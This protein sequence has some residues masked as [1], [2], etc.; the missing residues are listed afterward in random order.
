MRVLILPTVILATAAFSNA[1]AGTDSDD[2]ELIA[3]LVAR[4]SAGD[5]SVTRIDPDIQFVW[6][7]EMPDRRL[8]AGPFSVQWSGQ[9]LARTESTY[10]F[11]L[12]LEG[13][14]AVTLDGREILRG[15]RKMPGWVVSDEIQLAG[16]EHLIAIDFA[17]P[18]P[19]GAIRLFWASE[20]FPLEPIS[21][22]LLFHE[23]GDAGASQVERGE[24]LLTSLRCGACH[25]RNN[26]LPLLNAIPLRQAA[27]GL[28]DDWLVQW[29]Q[30]PVRSRPHARMPAFGFS[31]DEALSIAGYLRAQSATLDEVVPTVTDR[32]AAARRGERLFRSTGC[33]ACHTHGD[34][35]V[36]S[37]FSGGDLTDVGKRRSEVWLWGWLK[38]PAR[39]NRAHRMPVFALSDDER[40][41]LT[42]YLAG[43]S[44]PE[45]ALAPAREDAD[46]TRAGRAL[47]EQSRCNACHRDE[48]DQKP[49]EKISRLD[50]TVT[51]WSRACSEAAPD[52]KVFRPGYSLPEPD[53]LALRAAIASPPN[54]PEGPWQASLRWMKWNNCQKCHERDGGTGLASTAG[55]V[56]QIDPD[57]VG[58]SEALMPPDLTAVGDKLNDSCL[59]TAV[60]G[61]QET[62]RLPWLRVR[63]PQFP[64][65]PM[66]IPGLDRWMIDHDRIPES[67]HG[68]RA[69][70]SPVP[71]E[72]RPAGRVL[73]GTRGFSCVGC[74]KVGKFEP[75]N[76]ALATRGSDLFALDKRMRPEFFRRWVRSPLRVIPNMEMP[77]FDKPNPDL[78]EGN[79]DLQLTA[80][81]AALNDPNG[82]PTLDTSLIEQFLVVDKDGPARIVRDVFHVGEPTRPESVP[83]AFAVGFGNQTNLLFDLDRMALRAWWVGDFARQRS[84]GKSWNWELGAT[85]VSFTSSETPDVALVANED[86]LDKP[87]VARI[88]TGRF[89]KLHRYREEGAGVVIDYRLEFDVGSDRAMLEVQES[90]A[91][92]SSDGAGEA[93]WVRETTIRGIP[94]GYH[95]V[96]R[97]SNEVDRF[98]PLA[99]NE[100]GRAEESRHYSE[101]ATLSAAT[102]SPG[103]VTPKSSIEKLTVVPGYEGTRLPLPWSIMPTSLTWN[104]E[105]VLCFTSL[106]GHVFQARDTD[107]DGIEDTLIVFEEGLASPYGLIADGGDLLV[108]HKPELLRLRDEDGD[109]RSERREVVAD[110]WGFTDDYHDWTTGIVRDTKGNLY[111]GTG[112]DYARKGRSREQGRWR[113]KLLRIDRQ[114][115]TVPLGHALR[116]PTGLAINA[117]D[118]VFV[119]DNQG[120]QNT[121]NEINHLVEGGRYGVPSLFEE[122]F[123]ESPLP[124]AIQVPHPWTR[125]VNGIFFL[126]VNSSEGDDPFAGHG[127]G[128]EYDS[129]F[130]VR[131]TLQRVGATYQGAVY[132]FSRPPEKQSTGQFLGTL[133]G[134]VAPNGDIYIGSFLDSGWLGGPNVGDIVRLRRNGPLTC[135]IR[136]IQA[137]D[138]EFV[139]TFTSPVNREAAGMP[140]NYDISG[141][142][143]VW[144]GAYATP[145]SGRHKLAVRSATVAADGKSVIL[146]TDR[147]K[148]G[149][150]YEVHVGRL[151]GAKGEPLWPDVGHYTM[152]QIP[153][154]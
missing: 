149:H 97:R 7:Q 126:P 83:R 131:F 125:S 51:D 145:D 80:L 39:L 148:A 74:H 31:T 132:P 119:S 62:R 92:T 154:R 38:E 43:T 86:S 128:C 19:G 23:G 52:R 56:S 40:L 108:A 127:I 46:R 17:S 33:L 20:A 42:I 133:C 35:G 135:G 75:R 76:V 24:E 147:Q 53:R 85:P 123:S 142:T 69:T 48:D 47:V 143:R 110:G 77:S 15:N 8:P 114:G 120:V 138:G 1:Q 151:S 152:N 63:M 29:L 84:A 88:E 54:S 144:Q 115:T 112:S 140:E 121:F 109:G 26:D 78:L 139:I 44:Q 118:Q 150:V 12:Y 116:Y 129:R 70:G 16:G 11:H 37:T 68:T 25:P 94:K 100:N 136:E 103:K 21:A 9:V 72:L 55:K 117:D 6:R 87:L 49:S 2:G 99:V 105:G 98:V 89:G 146:R 60:L 153:R 18:A 81:W 130:L 93:G 34:L 14:G 67:E 111:V 73:A 65:S 41:D 30:N 96:M 137:F 13:N 50:R 10:R 27:V 95:P 82:A 36:D 141:Y 102:P 58:Q 113:G 101:Q 122:P 28:A 22:P 91:P 90:F 61:R 66:G 57:L 134:A 4:Y 64:A 106:K 32:A 5:A 71:A 107:G 3:G 124:P 79:H 104:H 45:P 59:A